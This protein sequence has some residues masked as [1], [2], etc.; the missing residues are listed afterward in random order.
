MNPQEFE[1]L[2][3]KKAQ[4]L[5]V[6]TESYFPSKAGNIALRFVNGNFRAQGWQGTSFKRW[7]SNSRNKTI[8]VKTGK[9]RAATYF[10]S[11]HGQFTLK[12]PMPY[13]R[14][15]N[16]GWRGI[17]NVSA[18]TRNVYKKTKVGTG[19][20]TKTGR[21]RKKTV[22]QKVGERQV[23]AHERKVVIP[24]R[25]FIPTYDSRS[26]V[27]DKAI[28]RMLSRDINKIMGLQNG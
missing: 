11:Q 5:K 13:A 14:K 7:K 25:Q 6:Y 9:M 15:H 21:E 17:V 20:F 16:E 22:D 26:P 10:T 27:L 19:K 18:H 2:L 3:K 12:N 28:L 24:R 1:K 8:L 4:E 23:R